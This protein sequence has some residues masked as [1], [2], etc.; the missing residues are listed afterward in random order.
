MADVEHPEDLLQSIPLFLL[1]SIPEEGISLLYPTNL[2]CCILLTEW[3]LL[4]AGQ[5]HCR[6]RREKKK[7]RGEASA[8]SDKMGPCVSVNGGSVGTAFVTGSVCCHWG[9]V[10]VPGFEEC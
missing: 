6:Q 10:E 2:Y 3:F 1:M 4:P 7:S 9:L 8:S 5:V